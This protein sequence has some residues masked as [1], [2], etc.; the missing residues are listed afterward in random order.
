ML[1]FNEI[2]M[3]ISSV[4][5]LILVEHRAWEIGSGQVAL[6]ANAFAFGLNG[7]IVIIGLRAG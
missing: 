7:A 1:I 4:A 2:A 3:V 5:L 6:A